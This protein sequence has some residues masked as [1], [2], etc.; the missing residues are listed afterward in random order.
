MDLRTATDAPAVQAYYWGRTLR[1]LGRIWFS[2][3]WPNPSAE[4]PVHEE[5]ASAWACHDYIA[6]I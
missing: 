1:A 2:T 4:P 6:D 3:R 5:E